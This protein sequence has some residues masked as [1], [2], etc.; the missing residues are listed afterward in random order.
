M[1]ESTS[2]LV[3]EG[4]RLNLSNLNKVFYPKINFTKHDIIDYYIK[5]A[6]Y[7]LPHLKNRAL[8]M[9][10]FPEG[11]HQ[12][13][14]YERRCPSYRPPWVNTVQVHSKTQGSLRYCTINNLPTLIWLVNLADLE[15]HTSLA[16]AKNPD[17]PTMVVFDLDPGIPATLY[18]CAEVALLIREKLSQLKLK[19][20]IKTSGS[21]GLQLYIPLNTSITY[22]ETKPFAHALAKEMQ[23]E[24][25]KKI[26][27][28]MAK[29]LRK[30]KVLIDWS[31]NDF[32]KTTVCAYSL[33][34]KET[35]TVSTPI[36]WQELEKAYRQ[37]KMERLVFAADDVLQR[38]QKM[39]DL[40]ADVLT[41]KQ[42]LP[43]S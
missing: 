40:M 14:F 7:L 20:W 22:D 39:G 38:V 21:K 41:C 11:V 19:S 28:R 35:P 16:V 10:R 29:N 4:K 37:K 23:K 42:K 31:Q 12:F 2:E 26:V 34:A 13:F 24:N 27:S 3:V 5:I 33:R 43:K 15:L 18:E 32:H 9:K 8:T 25:P 17:R 36:T 30:G 6:P 1:S